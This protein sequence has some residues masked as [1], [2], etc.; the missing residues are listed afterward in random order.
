MAFIYRRG[1][2]LWCK[3]KGPNGRWQAQATPF[4]VGDEAKA[5]ALADKAQREA[6]RSKS[7]GGTVADYA[8][9]W[10]AGR[11]TKG[12]ASHIDDVGRITNHVLPALGQ[13]KIADVRPRHVR[14]FIRALNA[15]ELAPRTVLNIFGIMRTMFNDA[16]VDEVITENPCKTRTGDLPGRVDADGEWRALAVFA[17]SEVVSLISDERI[18]VERRVLHALKALTGIRHGEAAGLRWRHLD[19]TTDVLARLLI[20]TSYNKKRTKTNVTRR[21][22]VHPALR[23]ILESWRANHWERVY[24]RSPGDDDLIVPARTMQPITANDAGRVFKR[25]LAEIGL[26]VDAGEA[27]DRG[28]HDLRS[29]HITALQEA[30]AALLLIET[31][32][33]TKQADVMSNYTRA[34]WPALCAEML[35][36]AFV[37]DGDPLKLCHSHVT[38]DLTLRNRWNNTRP[39]RDSNA[40]QRGS[41]SPDGSVTSGKDSRDAVTGGRIGTPAVTFR[42]TAESGLVS[43][44]RD[45]VAPFTTAAS[46]EVVAELEARATGRRSS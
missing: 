35:K 39:R 29:W 19:V 16:I 40:S 21:V 1:L 22:P 6:D 8:K 31:W 13:L 33:H 37:L 23:A 36:L 17:H 46:Y 20:A 44:I 30:G 38:R 12:N 2:R 28:G 15:T 32:T 34:S 3:F 9:T 7:T 24:G 14:D 42:V 18:P 45:F 41:G 4:N 10:I 43:T 11:E 5:Q 27:R 25:D 26:R